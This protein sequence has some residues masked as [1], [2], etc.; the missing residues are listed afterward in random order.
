MNKRKMALVPGIDKR[1]D[2]GISL[3]TSKRGKEL[4]EKEQRACVIEKR[5]NKEEMEMSSNGN[6]KS[7]RIGREEENAHHLYD[8]MP[9]RTAY[10]LGK[11][12]F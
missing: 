8:K 2:S 9:K 3:L 12:H 1:I 6:G 11:I 5:M 4:K 7:R 10:Y